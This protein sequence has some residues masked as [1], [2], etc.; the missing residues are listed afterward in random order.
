[1]TEITFKQ[2]KKYAKTDISQLPQYKL[3]IMGDCATQHLATAIRGY[4]AYAGLGLSYGLRHRI[5]RIAE[6]HGKVYKTG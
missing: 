2:L 4:G 6:I 3:A 1:M 5:L